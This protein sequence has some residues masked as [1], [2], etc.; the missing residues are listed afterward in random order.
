LNSHAR[1]AT[2]PTHP[3]SDEWNGSGLA[4]ILRDE[5]TTQ[6]TEPFGSSQEGLCGWSKRVSSRSVNTTLPTEDLRIKVSKERSLE[7]ALRVKFPPL[8]ASRVNQIVNCGHDG[9]QVRIDE[10]IGV[11]FCC[12]FCP[13][14]FS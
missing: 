5:I 3:K 7:V 4:K 2:K 12:L 9:A 8:K 14:K 13:C 10:G 6:H 1:D 11:K